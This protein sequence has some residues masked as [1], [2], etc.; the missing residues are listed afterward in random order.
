MKAVAGYLIAAV[1]LAIVAVVLFRAGVL[2]RDMAAAQE[3]AV[4]QHYEALE[5]T[6]NAAEPYYEYASRLPWVGTR[7]VN[8]LRTRRAAIQYWQHRYTELVPRG[9]DP[10]A[11]V[12]PDN[13]DLQFLVASGMV[14]R[15]GA[16]AKDKVATM[17][18]LDE[19]ISAFSTV[20][21]NASRHEDAAYNYEYL[22]K[23]RNDIDK[24]RRKPGGP[25][26]EPGSP[27]GAAGAPQDESDSAKFKVY[28]PLDSKE[29]N[30]TGGEAGK[31]APMKRKG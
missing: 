21:K 7:A 6:L 10:L 22:V 18:A 19:G 27:H 12:P 1:I 3:Q 23:L 2:D 5:A 31:A 25:P 28:V 30:D 17:N 16:N 8:D 4:D 9:D 24:G 11:G 13:V 14:Q 26:S 20:L 29:R 15:S